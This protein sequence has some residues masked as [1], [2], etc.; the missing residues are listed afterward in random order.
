MDTLF[1]PRR[2][3]DLPDWAR[4]ATAV[5]R[6]LLAKARNLPISRT[7]ATVY[8]LSVNEGMALVSASDAPVTVS[9]PEAKNAPERV[10]VIKKIDSTANPVSVKPSNGELIDGAAVMALTTQYETVTVVSD[11]KQWWII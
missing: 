6:G 11:T 3:A 10:F 8:P 5:I 2:S 7:S 1:E 4:E 9:L